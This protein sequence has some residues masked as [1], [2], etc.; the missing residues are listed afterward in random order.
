MK[1]TSIKSKT[2]E[3]Y[4]YIYKKYI[5]ELVEKAY[6]QIYG[7][8][9]GTNID[10]AD[11]LTIIANLKLLELC[12]S[13]KAKFK[14]Y[15]LTAIGHAS[16]DEVRKVVG[17][18]KNKNTEEDHKKELDN[19]QLIK[20]ANKWLKEVDE[21]GIQI[22]QI[23]NIDLSKLELEKFDID[24]LV[25]KTS[26][27][28]ILKLLFRYLVRREVIDIFQA[29]ILLLK[30]AFNKTF[31]E[32]SFYLSTTFDKA[33][34]S[35]YKA[36]DKIVYY[37]YFL[38]RI[39]DWDNWD[40]SGWDDFDFED[41]DFREEWKREAINLREEKIDFKKCNGNRL[42]KAYLRLKKRKSF[43]GYDY[44]V[45]LR[46]LIGF[47]MVREV[48]KKL[49]NCPEFKELN[50]E[51][52]F[53]DEYLTCYNPEPITEDPARRWMDKKELDLFKELSLKNYRN[54]RGKNI[55][56]KAYLYKTILKDMQGYREIILKNYSEK[57]NDVNVLTRLSK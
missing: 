22:S 45:D 57:Y 1:K 51:N 54:F 40:N 53:L 5:Y 35:S 27:V 43:F 10:D 34:K 20:D 8:T 29:K 46:K 49:A 3:D 6:K 9:D 37:F 52:N 30:I 7:L 31:Q 16:T 25:F 13:G 2:F 38:H 19:A 50:L 32:V 21:S 17:K 18:V 24:P 42:K 36:K 48:E 56:E 55:F 39:N 15:T 47:L 41:F 11:D 26:L 4:F 12:N 44:D 14:N 28:F 33:V 23:L